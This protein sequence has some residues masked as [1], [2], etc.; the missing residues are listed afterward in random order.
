MVVKQKCPRVS[1]V[2]S[3]AKSA[4]GRHADNMHICL[5]TP[6]R[7]KGRYM[8]INVHTMYRA[9]NDDQTSS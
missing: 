3:I 2:N 6:V 8:R 7:G 4:K 5:I 9:I 1:Q